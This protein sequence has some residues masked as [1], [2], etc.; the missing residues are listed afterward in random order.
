MEFVKVFGGGGDCQF[1][2]V[3]AQAVDMFC[4]FFC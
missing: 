1:Y 2:D 4:N 3:G